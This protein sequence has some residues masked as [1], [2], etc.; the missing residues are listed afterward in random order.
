MNS[1][2]RVNSAVML[3]LLHGQIFVLIPALI[4][5]AA[6]GMLVVGLAKVDSIKRNVLIFGLVLIVALIFV[7][8]GIYF[9]WLSGFWNTVIATNFTSAT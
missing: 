5:F 2:R 1:R 3:L 9:A 6:A 7:L 4:S 8:A